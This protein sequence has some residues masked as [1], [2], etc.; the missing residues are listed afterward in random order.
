MKGTMDSLNLACKLWG[1]SPDEICKVLTSKGMGKA[2]GN[3][4]V[5]YKL[6]QAQDA[7]AAMVK[8]VYG[9]LFELM[10][11]SINKELMGSGENRQNFIGVLDIFGFESFEVNSFEQL[12]INFCNEKLQFHFNEHIFKMELDLYALENI[13]IPASAFVDNQPTLDLL[14]VPA[15][16]VFSMIDEEINVPRGSDEGLLNKIFQAYNTGKTGDVNNHPN[17]LKPKSKDCVNHMN[18]FGILHY[19]GPVFYNVANFLEKNKDSLHEDIGGV[20]REANINL[21]SDMFPI[22]PP[23]APAGG[24]RG[25]TMGGKKKTL[26]GQ[27]KAQLNELIATLNSTYPHFVR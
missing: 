6:V 7:R 13:H 22:P 18:N 8:K 12:C 1:V 9:E 17:L 14:E 5:A 2:V 27:F 21:V 10:V 3:V 26:G 15:K 25:S 23:A 4:R 20:L 19:A 24:R 16:G 11:S